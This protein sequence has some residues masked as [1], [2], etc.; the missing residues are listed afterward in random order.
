MKPDPYNRPASFVSTHG[1]ETAKECAE[2]EA[3]N[4][5]E[6]KKAIETEGIDCDFVL[7]RAVD[8]LMSESIRDKMKANVELLR[9]AG[10]S[11]MKD[12]YYA[13][14]AEAEQVS[15]ATTYTWGSMTDCLLSAIR[16]KRSKGLPVIYRRHRLAVQTNPLP[17]LKGPRRRRQPA[18]P[19]AR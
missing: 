9:K 12:V 18:D 7:T 16:C 11:V 17:P 4:L 5:M 8:A 1:I 14:G 3:K 15:R 19:Y 2:F 6:V 10:V 13:D